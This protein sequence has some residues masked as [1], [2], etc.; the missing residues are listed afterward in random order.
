MRP[1]RPADALGRLLGE[2]LAIPRRLDTEAVATIIETVELA[3]CF[4]AVTGDLDT[5]ASQIIR[6]AEKT[7][8]G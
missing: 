1:L 2:C 6:I 8:S 5:A 4:D 7:A 3:A